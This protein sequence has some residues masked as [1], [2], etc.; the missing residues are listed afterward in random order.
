[1]KNTIVKDL[2]RLFVE[3]RAELR[4]E[5]CRRPQPVTGITF[6]IDHII[7]RAQGGTDD[8]GNLALSCPS[9]NYRKQ[10]K[11][12]AEDP[13]SREISSLFNPRVDRWKDHFRWSKTKISIIGRTK[14]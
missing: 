6:H 1:M 10:D 13:K 9:C 14:T 11:I 2:K 12:S 3:T 4:C 5:Y 7:P 8:W